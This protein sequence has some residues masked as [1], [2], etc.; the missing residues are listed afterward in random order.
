MKMPFKK[1]LV[2]HKETEQSV[3]DLKETILQIAISFK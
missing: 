3:T 2:I 1:C